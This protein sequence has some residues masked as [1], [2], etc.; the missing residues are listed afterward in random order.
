MDIESKQERLSSSDINT[1]LT[2]TL[3]HTHT[4]THTHTCLMVLSSF[5]REFPGSGNIITFSQFLFIALE[6]FIFTMHFGRKKPVIPI[7]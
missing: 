3:T 1:P 4:H 6:G 5:F 2:H 7:S